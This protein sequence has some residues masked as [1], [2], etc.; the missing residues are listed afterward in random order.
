[1]FGGGEAKLPCT[2][3]KNTK[4]RILYTTV[5]YTTLHNATLLRLH[6]SI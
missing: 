1:M 2:A 4:L 5:T 6:Y 3:V